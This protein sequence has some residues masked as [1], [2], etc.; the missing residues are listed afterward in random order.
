MSNVKEKTSRK[1]SGQ[2]CGLLGNWGTKNSLRSAEI[3]G[4]PRFA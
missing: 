1:L 4:L 2:S 3:I